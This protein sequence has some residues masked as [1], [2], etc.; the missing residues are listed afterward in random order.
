VLGSAAV[1]P[2][3][4]GDQIV[5]PDLSSTPALARQFAVGKTP[6]SPG[7]AVAALSERNFVADDIP[8]SE[9][10]ALAQFFAAAF[11]AAPGSPEWVLAS[12]KFAVGEM[13]NDGCISSG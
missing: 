5:C 7:C 1:A 13:Q 4:T 8:V 6:A 2:S 12:A 11:G 3:A 10:S 9:E